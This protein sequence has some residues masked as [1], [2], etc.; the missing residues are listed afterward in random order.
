MKP[1]VVWLAAH[2]DELDQ[3]AAELKRRAD[4]ARRLAS[5]HLDLRNSDT[6]YPIRPMHWLPDQRW[7]VR[8][9]Q[10]GPLFQDLAPWRGYRSSVMQWLLQF[11]HPERGW[12]PVDRNPFC[13]VLHPKAG[14]AAFL[15][16]ED[17]E[18]PRHWIVLDLENYVREM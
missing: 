4:F 16:G 8:N 9:V 18:R 1:E 17:D 5:A 2:A 13:V 15:Y 11:D 7:K 10:L 3:Q 12:I 6:P 14:Y